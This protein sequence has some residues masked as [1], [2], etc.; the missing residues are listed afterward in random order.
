MMIAEAVT[1]VM[2][3]EAALRVTVAVMTATVMTTV[4]AS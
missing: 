3:S 1:T 4:A 2:A